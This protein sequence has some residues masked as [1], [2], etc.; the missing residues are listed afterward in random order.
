VG[1]GRGC[2]GAECGLVSIAFIPGAPWLTAVMHVVC[3]TAC[4]IGAGAAL[5]ADE[6]DETTF[7]RQAGIGVDDVR[8]GVVDA[9]RLAAAPVVN[10]HGHMGY[11]RSGRQRVGRGGARRC[12]NHAEGFSMVAARMKPQRRQ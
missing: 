7:A 10:P 12:G 3:F 1:A 4:F 8:R 6:V 11:D 5:C 9:A 2:G